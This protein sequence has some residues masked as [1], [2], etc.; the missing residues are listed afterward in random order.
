MSINEPEVG[1]VVEQ[2]DW[3]RF[4]SSIERLISLHQRTLQ[5][6][7]EVGHRNEALREELRE[8][9]G[10]RSL[11]VDSRDRVL[12]SVKAKSGFLDRL[13][14]PSAALL[15]PH[16]RVPKT[17]SGQLLGVPG[18]AGLVK[19]GR[20]G[21]QFSRLDRFCD[22]CGAPFNTLICRCGRELTP[23]GKFCDSCG[24]KIFG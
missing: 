22:Q 19:C 18:S 5:R 4:L 15:R 7:K 3:E 23:N 2:D 12:S 16:L 21:R 20:C 9:M 6:L 10:L 24:Q 13:F 14:G 11:H 17:L 8:A 1:L